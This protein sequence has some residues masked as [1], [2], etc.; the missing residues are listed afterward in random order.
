MKLFS[1]P[2]EEESEEPGEP[3]SEERD[4]MGTVS[5]PFVPV[6]GEWSCIMLVTY[7][8]GWI[9]QRDGITLEMGERETPSLFTRAH[10]ISMQIFISLH[11]S[12]GLQF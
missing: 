8:Q 4:I 1:K 5:A 10:F 3:D 2:T 9:I 7:R 6:A 12:N 11:S